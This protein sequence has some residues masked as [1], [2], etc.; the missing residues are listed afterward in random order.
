MA[1]STKKTCTLHFSPYAILIT[2]APQKLQA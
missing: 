2:E 1:K